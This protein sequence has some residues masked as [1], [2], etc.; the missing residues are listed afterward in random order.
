MPSRVRAAGVERVL[1]VHLAARGEPQTSLCSALDSLGVGERIDWL[2]SKSV[3]ADIL[4]AARR[5]RPTLVWMQLQTPGVLSP[6][7]IV[8][9]RAACDPRVAICTWSGDVANNNSFLRDDWAA[10]LG[11]ACDLVLHS[12][13]THVRRLRERG[14]PA[15]YLQIG[16]DEDRYFPGQDIDYGTS[17][18]VVF[19][20]HRYSHDLCRSVGDY[21]ESQSRED[22]AAAVRTFPRPQ[23]GDGVPHSASGDVYRRALFGVSVSLSSR[24]ERYSSDRLLRCLACG[25]VTVVKR[26]DDME[27]WGLIHGKNCLVFDTVAEAVDLIRDWSGRPSAERFRVGSSGAKLAHD[28]HTWGIRMRELMYLVN[29]V[30]G[31]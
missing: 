26:F 28:H 17:H 11:R 19:L 30:R 10:E 31:S 6:A 29:I 7:D 1:H 9:L 22:I 13:M 20:Y 2:N 24:M 14:A 15:A 5:I 12:S 4:S 3:A 16:Y 18:D 23:C 27:S 21:D 25:V 8:E